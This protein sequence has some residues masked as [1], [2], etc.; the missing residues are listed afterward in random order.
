MLTW[1]LYTSSHG[2]L[3][4]EALSYFQKLQLTHG[5]PATQSS[6]MGANGEANNEELQALKQ[7][8]VI[9]RDRLEHHPEVKRFA[10]VLFLM[11]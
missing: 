10:G 6:R 8:V 4:L 7:E 3:L 2:R 5:L 11:P 1:Y 9:M